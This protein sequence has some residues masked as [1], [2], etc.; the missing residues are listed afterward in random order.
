MKRLLRVAMIALL[1]LGVSIAVMAEGP[2]GKFV[3]ANAWGWVPATKPDASVT[4]WLQDKTGV[5]FSDLPAMTGDT[6]QALLVK[7]AANDLPDLITSADFTLL[8]RL[9]TE[10]R[11]IPLDTYYADKQNYPGFS[12]IDSRVIDRWRLSDGKIYNVPLRYQYDLNK[13]GTSDGFAWGSGTWT[14][15]NDLLK[16][17][18]MKVADLATQAGV[19]KFLRK[20]KGTFDPSGLPYIPLGFHWG[21][22]TPAGWTRMIEAQY[23]VQPWN[24]VGGT[25]VPSWATAGSKAAWK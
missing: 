2:D 7:M 10:G 12:S 16:A 18:G 15:R 21:G 3:W 11:V 25:M 4:K 19:E 20:V 23:G 1:F 14:V 5:Y 22:I 6:T 24:N 13:Y 17:A 8:Q 9:V